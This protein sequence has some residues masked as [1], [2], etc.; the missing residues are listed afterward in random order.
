MV[1]PA[2]FMVNAMRPPPF[3][4]RAAWHAGSLMPVTAGVARLAGAKAARTGAMPVDG[5]GLRRHTAPEGVEALSAQAV[6]TGTAPGHG[7]QYRE[8]GAR[9]HWSRAV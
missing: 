2:H 9:H 3:A 8:T 7:Q 1:F 5:V 4:T 6:Q